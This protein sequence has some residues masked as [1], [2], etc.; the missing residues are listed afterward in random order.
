MGILSRTL[1]R[2][3]VVGSCAVLVAV[4]AFA[5]LPEGIA[6]RSV[7]I[8]SDGTRLA[9]DLFWPTSWKEGEKLPAIVL[10]HGWGGT[11]GHLNQVYAPAFAAQ[12]YFVLTFD[13]RG[14]GAS[15]GRLVALGEIP[16][17]GP[18]GTVTVKAREIRD[19]VSPVERIEDIRAAIAW[20]QLEPGVDGNRIG[21]W[22][23][24]FGGGNVVAAAA[25]DPHVKCVCSQVGDVNARWGWLNSMRLLL[26][27]YPKAEGTPAELEE[28]LQEI[29]ERLSASAARIEELLNEDKLAL[30]FWSNPLNPDGL[31]L[32]TPQGASDPDV[33][34]LA[35]KYN[36]NVKAMYSI[37]ANFPERAGEII[38][39]QAAQRARGLADPFPQGKGFGTV[40]PMSGIADPVQMVEYSAMDYADLIS[41]PVQI[42]EAGK[43]ELMDIEHVGGAL[44]R[45]LQGQVPVERH[46]FDCSH[47]EIYRSP[48][49][50]EAIRLQIAWFNKHLKGEITSESKAASSDRELIQQ[51]I[52]GM[53][54]AFEAGDVDAYLEYFSDDYTTFHHFDK[55]GFRE[56]LIQG[57]QE[58]EW[59]SSW[60][61]SRLTID[62]DTATVIMMSSSGFGTFPI[63]T[64]FVKEA[65]G[66][67]RILSQG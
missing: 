32:V 50:E 33:K 19:L 24:S 6:T 23:T 63:P 51:S 48:Q 18:D 30:D 64:T 34:T 43:E 13:Y 21:L 29:V 53:T 7:E 15:D 67:W 36:D 58:M 16:D 45:K 47:F 9:G 3:V 27:K 35:E 60:D 62:G 28:R 25:L 61:M 57:W 11:K 4:S 39:M 5:Q 52:D 65:D 12:G 8:W 14:W 66:V 41:C 46:V 54:A 55:A 26:S 31:I 44:Y 2:R 38:T 17:P 20:L 1:I 40:P 59:S 49:V 10:C 56:F 42:I 37:L 22:G